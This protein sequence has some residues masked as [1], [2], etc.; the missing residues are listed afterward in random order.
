MKRS[1]SVLIASS[2]LA[3]FHGPSDQGITSETHRAHVG[4]IVF[5]S[6]QIKHGAE[7]PTSFI[8]HCVLGEPCYG[9][10]YLPSS[11]RDSAHDKYSGAFALRATVDGTPMPD[12]LFQMQS[13][14]STYNFT[15]FRARG[16]GEPWE[17]P[18]W[19]LEKVAPKLTPGDHQL[20]LDVLAVPSGTAAGAGK[21]IATGKITFTV[22]PNAQRIV[23]PALARENQIL[24][25]AQAQAAQQQAAWQAEA[26]RQGREQAAQQKADEAARKASCLPDGKE[27]SDSFACCSQHMWWTLSS[28]KRTGN[29]CCN[30]ETYHDPDGKHPCQ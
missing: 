9:R 8:D 20:Q 30:P 16:D 6:S 11:L 24:A 7:N 23:S 28:D 18:K 15:L 25:G 22:P 13:F 29:Y 27:T 26:D 4:G 12:G 14:W 17:H 19:F 3:C 5:A 21:P 10:F 2:L 1:W